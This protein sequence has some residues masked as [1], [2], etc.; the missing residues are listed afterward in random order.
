MNIDFRNQL[1]F[2]LAV[3][4][5]STLTSCA[6]TAR[7][8]T[9]I[10]TSTPLVQPTTE[11][12]PV[13][14]RVEP[15][16]PPPTF[17]AD[18]S[19]SDSANDMPVSFLDVVSFRAH[20]DE[21]EET[22]KVVLRMRDIPYVAPLGGVTN[23]LEYFWAVYVYRDPSTDAQ[24]ATPVDYYFGLNTM[25]DDPYANT[26]A[27]ILGTPVTVPIHAIF[28]VISIYS[29]SG[30]ESKPTV[31]VSPDIDT[32][33]LAGHIPGITSGS[34][35]S[36]S[37][38][39][40]DGTKDRPDVAPS[41]VSTSLSTPLPEATQPAPTPEEG[42]SQLISA[43]NVYAFP[44]PDHYA[45]DVLT[46]VV[47]NDG[48]V[49]EETFLVSI[50]LD[51]MPPRD[52]P[53]NALPFR[54]VVIPIALDTT[55]LLGQ[56][57]LRLT[58]A[59]GNLNETYSFEV[60]HADRRPANEMSAAWMVQET[61]CCIFHFLSGTAAARDIDF[62]AENFQQGARDLESLIGREVDLKMDVYLLDRMLNN[63]GFGGGGKLFISYTDRYFGPTVG[64]A[65]L[66]TLARHEFSHAADI[67]LENA[68]DGVDYN[69]EGLAVYIAGGHFKPEPLAKRGAALYDLGH[70]A[71]V[72]DFIPQHELSYLHAALILT[73]IV[74]TYGEDK[75]WEFFSAD[76]D[77]PDGELLPMGDAIQAT[78]AIPLAEFDQGFRAWLEK[79]DPGEQLEDLRLT[80]ELQ[81]ARR[82]YQTMY[83]PQPIYMMMDV[84]DAIIDTITRPE[85]RSLVMREARA[86]ANIAIELLIANA[87]R[88]IIASAYPEAEQLIQA[89]KEVVSTGDFENPR[90]KEYLDIVLA[91]EEAGYEVLSLNIQNGYAT[92]QV[93]K[94]SPMTTILVL[95]N[96]NSVWQIEP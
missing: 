34:Q 60:L 39:Y 83:S 75:L 72:T 88:A 46:L 17:K 48:N 9:P 44:G 35:F 73:Y 92:A 45:G 82:E 51:N 18:Q 14:T 85:N 43:G 53:A 81:D 61:D 32:L 12:R 42:T 95:R 59:D 49:P 20:V 66:Q 84:T 30:S 79:N 36:F 80:I 74:E 63:G 96:V 38:E 37:I 5:I 27:P 62:I 58:T 28:E 71:P 89:I 52:V 70:Y 78:F 2:C 7:T 6:P 41:P 16:F 1:V 10:S 22:V 40:Y 77:T 54:Q 8:T 65:G 50:T 3:S 55:D 24:A 57:T 56:H 19:Y 47:Q 94:E 86:P 76:A 25:I 87:Q 93:T 31:E 90:A 67:G 33:T 69:Y 21:Q 64:S 4:L 91:A 26:T 11:V 23:L 68:G 29:A 13:E 15:K